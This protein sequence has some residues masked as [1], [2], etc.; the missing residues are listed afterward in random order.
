MLILWTFN[1][2]FRLWLHTKSSYKSPK[3][4]Q[5]SAK[6]WR[7]FNFY[8]PMIQR[9]HSSPILCS[10][11]STISGAPKYRR[12]CSDVSGSLADEPW[13]KGCSTSC[14]MVFLWWVCNSLY[15][16]CVVWGF[17]RR[18][19]CVDLL[20]PLKGIHFIYCHT[21]LPGPATC[22]FLQKPRGSK[23]SQK[24]S[25]SIAWFKRMWSWK[26]RWVDVDF[27]LGLPSPKISR[28]QSRRSNS[29]DFFLRCVN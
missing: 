23:K 21:W 14:L 5:K 15:W 24:S 27:S 22:Q 25:G 6:H 18:L 26:R 19:W 9:W 3:N 7:E 2:S 13:G 8:D 28:N 4:H 29:P 17:G 20:H 11:W 10:G 1:L 16:F 12:L